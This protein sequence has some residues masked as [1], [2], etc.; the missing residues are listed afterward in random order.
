MMLI[1]ISNRTAHPIMW[2][3]S[4]LWRGLC[5]KNWCANRKLNMNYS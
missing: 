4:H 5:E 3:M 1:V 2:Q